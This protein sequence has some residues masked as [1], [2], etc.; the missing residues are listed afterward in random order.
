MLK[1][2]EG[3]E[4]VHYL[5][6]CVVIMVLSSGKEKLFKFESDH[7]SATC[8]I[9]VHVLVCFFSHGFGLQY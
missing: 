7:A 2:V 5:E 3:G 8:L 6:A 4:C 9:P 1:G